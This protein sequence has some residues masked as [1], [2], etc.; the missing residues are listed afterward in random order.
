MY[1]ESS[2]PKGF[3]V[4]WSTVGYAVCA[5]FNLALEKAYL[6]KKAGQDTPFAIGHFGTDTRLDSGQ[7]ETAW[8]ERGWI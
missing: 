8:Q 2:L 3:W 5:S 1:I 6:L 7:I 4:V